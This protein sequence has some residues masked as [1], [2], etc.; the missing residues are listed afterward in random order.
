M[1]IA[2]LEALQCD[3]AVTRKYAEGYSWRACAEEFRRNLEPLPKPEK[4]KFWLRLKAARERAR[5]RRRMNRERKE[6]RRAELAARRN[7][8]SG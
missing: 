6:K 2:A 7:G 4:K 1:K 3:R 5:E 8:A